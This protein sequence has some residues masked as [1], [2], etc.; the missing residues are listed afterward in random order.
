MIAKALKSA[1]VFD[2]Y[3]IVVHSLFQDEVKQGSDFIGV[4][5][6]YGVIVWLSK[7][8]MN[9]GCERCVIGT[10]KLGLDLFQ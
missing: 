4:I 9:D 8:I 10:Q 1:N 7:K 3:R 6:T 2:F 5:L